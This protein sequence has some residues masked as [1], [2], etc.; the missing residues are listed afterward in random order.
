[1][2]D[3][4]SVQDIQF[5]LTRIV[6][7]TT[8]P[9]TGQQQIQD[10]QNQWMEAALNLPPMTSLE[11]A[12]WIAFLVACN[13]MANVFQLPAALAAL[14]PTGTVPGGYWRLKSNENKFSITIAFLYGF[15]FE[16]REA[17]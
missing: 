12:S 3:A 14:V 5:K 4:P 6:G 1:M 10:W 7:S 8:S 13:G 2:P 16:I 9:F 15:N 11:A 17:V